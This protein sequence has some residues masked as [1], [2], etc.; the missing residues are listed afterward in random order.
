M[1][2]ELLD[3]VPTMKFMHQLLK[4]KEILTFLNDLF[5]NL[6]NNTIKLTREYQGITLILKRESNTF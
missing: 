3:N 1:K 2:K 6:L 5:I 4:N